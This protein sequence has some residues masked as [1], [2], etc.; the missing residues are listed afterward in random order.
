MNNE[1]AKVWETFERKVIPPGA[2]RIQRQE[3]RRAFYAGAAGMFG[4]IAQIDEEDEDEAVA[5]LEALKQ[6]LMVF[7]WRVGVD[8]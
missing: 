3:M 1:F 5:Q 4:L 8:R 2:S 6:E 7:T